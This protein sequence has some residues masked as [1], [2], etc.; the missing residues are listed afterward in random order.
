MVPGAAKMPTVDMI[1][2]AFHHTAWAKAS[3]STQP[4]GNTTLVNLKTF[5][6]VSW[7]E[8]GYEPDEV[9]AIDPVTMFGYNVEIRPRLVSFVYHFGD[10]ASLGPTTSRGGVYPDGDVVHTYGRPGRYPSRV[11]VTFGAEFRINGGTWVSIPDT[12]TVTQPSTTV[13]VRE[14]KSVLVNR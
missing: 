5:Y 6:R 11:D 8:R 4:R 14:A 1:A 10:G 13:T 7:S 12:V 2:E 3:I 9:D